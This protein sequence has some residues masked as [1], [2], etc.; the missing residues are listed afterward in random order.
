LS[1]KVITL[2]LVEASMMPWARAALRS[3]AEPGE[4]AETQASRPAGEAG[5]V[6]QGSSDL[7]R[8]LSYREPRLTSTP[9]FML[10]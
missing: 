4:A 1:A 6:V 3:W 2:A 8:L 7:G 9:D 5:K 10:P